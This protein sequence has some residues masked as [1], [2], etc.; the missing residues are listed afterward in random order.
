MP[1][2]PQNVIHALI[3]ERI[4]LVQSV[5]RRINLESVLDELAD[6]DAEAFVRDLQTS[7]DSAPSWQRLIRALTI[8]ETYFFRNRAHFDLLKSTILPDIRARRQDDLRFNIWSAACATGEEAYSIAITLREAMLDLPQWAVH[9]M[10]T[11]LNG[12]A[13][14]SAQEAVYRSWSFRH[15]ENDFRE[16]YFT[17]VE[18]GLRLIAPVR[19]KVVFRQHNLLNP[20]PMSQIDLIFCCNVLLYFE[21]SQVYRVEDRLFDALNPGG[22][23]ILGQAEALQFKRERWA[24]HIFPGAVIYQKP[25]DGMQ[26]AYYHRAAAETRPIEH[27]ESQ[28]ETSLPSP[29]LLQTAYAEAVRLMRMKQY[30]AARQMLQN[31]LTQSPDNEAAH[32]L[33]GCLL[34]NRG[35]LP[36]AH[37][38]IDH[39]LRLDGLQADAHYLKGVLF[40]EKQDTDAAVE[41]LRAALYCHRGHPLAATILGHLYAQAGDERRAQRTWE[42]ALDYLHDLAPETP[43]SDLSDLTAEGVSEFLSEQIRLLDKAEKP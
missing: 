3:E 42:E 33:L 38:Q 14:A 41:A 25:L 36:D 6:G 8:G 29:A 18:N 22:W 5:Q 43:I 34:A 15:T 30:D 11:D 7:P 26:T 4:G 27:A 9:L 2:Q 28:P 40:L 23:L 37:A 17:P 13:L 31:I 39:A 1:I 21:K 19:E 16:R 10:G 12:Y 24:T 32:I 35:E 20:P